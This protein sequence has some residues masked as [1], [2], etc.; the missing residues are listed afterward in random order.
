M[1]VRN[2]LVLSFIAFSLG[3][4][5]AVAAGAAQHPSFALANSLAGHG[6]YKQAVEEYK[7]ALAAQPGNPK[8]HHM[9]GRTLALMGLLQSAVD[10]Y[11]VV[12]KLNGGKKDAEL[13]NDI[14]VALAAVGS[15]DLP[16]A[17][18][19]L[20][21][22]VT[23]NPKFIAAYNNL[24]V[25]LSRLGDYRAAR[26]VFAQSLKMQ[27]TNKSIEKKLADM[28]GKLAQSKHFDYAMPKPAEVKPAET[29]AVTP[30]AT[31]ADVK[32]VEQAPAAVV[33]TPPVVKEPVKT[34]TEP[35][36][37][38]AKP[39]TAAV[40]PAAKPVVAKPPVETAAPLAVSPKANPNVMPTTT[41]AP[42]AGVTTKVDGV[43]TSLDA[44]PTTTTTTTVKTT[45][46]TT[47]ATLNSSTSTTTTTEGTGT[48]TTGASTTTGGTG[49]TGDTT[50]TTP[51]P[52]TTGAPA[53]A[54]PTPTDSSATTPTEAPTSTT[55]TGAPTAPAADSTEP[56]TTTSTD[57][58]ADT[59]ST[60]DSE[61]SS[62]SKPKQ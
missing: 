33:T 51:P 40:K 19:H 22:A 34:V 48:T 14:G 46:T 57:K 30:P 42:V 39:A 3:V 1:R 41:N 45:T 10:E 56:A 32:P 9:Y 20:K 13:E 38:V 35:V 55:P 17:A 44:T 25:A 5:P 37:P 53:V 2:S 23:L 24:G 54:T 11:R 29:T 12:L 36:K 62:E 43:S 27:P 8:V 47:D 61:S 28:N 52:A 6:N 31:P 50:T 7:K 18:I 16:E 15:D 26:D 59:S 21:N 60:T 4:L 58:P 49:T